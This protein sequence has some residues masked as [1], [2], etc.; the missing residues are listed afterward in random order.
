MDLGAGWGWPE[1]PV[2][3]ERFWSENLNFLPLA[4]G[5]RYGWL[6]AD[7]L[8]GDWSLDTG[9]SSTGCSNIVSL[10]CAKGRW[11]MVLV[12]TVDVSYAMYFQANPHNGWVHINSGGQA[13]QAQYKLYA[14]EPH[15]SLVEAQTKSL[16]SRQH[17]SIINMQM[18][19]AGRRQAAMQQPSVANSDQFL[20]LAG[21]RERAAK[22]RPWSPISDYLPLPLPPPR[23][24]AVEL[25]ASLR[26]FSLCLE[27]ATY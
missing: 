23:R 16:K 2:A 26:E 11:S 18:R 6:A 5:R 14:N 13:S 24:P 21:S 25:S 15:W 8:I 19:G 22:P 1:W 17:Q 20:W 12:S 10:L 7:L 27:K 4:G 3:S 9:V